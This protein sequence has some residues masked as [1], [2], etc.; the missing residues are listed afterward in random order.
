MSEL[1]VEI[2][3]DR[4]TLQNKSASGISQGWQKEPTKFYMLV[5]PTFS[6]TYLVL[7]MY[8]RVESRFSLL[9]SHALVLTS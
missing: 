4:L 8:L 9:K 1:T 6:I 3:T 7:F 5:L 2:S